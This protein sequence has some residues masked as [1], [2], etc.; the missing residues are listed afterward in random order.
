[1]SALLAA[2]F[3][4][5]AKLTALS[6]EI[7]GLIMATTHNSE[8]FS[9]DITLMVGIDLSILDQT[10]RL[11]GAT[12]Q[13]FGVNT[14]GHQKKLSNWAGSSYYGHFSVVPAFSTTLLALTC[15]SD[16]RG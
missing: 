5:S 9:G 1:M 2:E 15:G 3:L 11:T 7:T 12:Q 10:Q 16:L 14:P 4:T 13:A 8:P 6:A